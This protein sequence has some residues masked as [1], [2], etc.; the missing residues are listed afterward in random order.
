MAQNYFKGEIYYIYPRETVGCEQMGGRPGIIVSND[1]GNNHSKI[2]EVVFLTTKEKKPLPTHVEI[3]S[4]KC[5]SIA[6]CEQIETVSKERIGDYINSVTQNELK[7]LDRAM[8]ISLDIN[9]NLKG[10]KKFEA[11]EK[12]IEEMEIEENS[13]IEM[14][15]DKKDSQGIIPLSE[16]VT[17]SIE[18]SPEYIRACT[19]RDIYK[20]LY[21]N[22]LNESRRTA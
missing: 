20:E 7:E 10:S 15:Q 3:N 14:E 22:L 2:V 11:W 1:I 17:V 5:R 8:L 13:N 18:T 12:L 16:P 6:L 19:E 9:C 21:M 4:G